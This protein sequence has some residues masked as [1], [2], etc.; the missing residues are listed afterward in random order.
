M[1]KLSS[2]VKDY[3]VTRD[4]TV[5]ALRDVSIDFRQN[6]FVSI[7]GPSG[8]GKTT[9][10][11]IVGG[12]DKYTKGDLVINGRSTKE[13]SDRDWD[14][15]RNHRIGFIFQTYNLIPHQTVLGNVELA[16]TIAGLSKSE[17]VE[18]AKKALAHVGLADQYYK[19]P[20]QLSG[21]QCQR[22]AIA[23]ALVNDPEIVLADEPTGA[24]DTVTSVQIMALLKEI[25]KDRLVIMVTHNA[26][27]AEE[28]ST[29]IIRLLDGQLQSDDNP[30]TAEE[31]EEKPEVPIPLHIPKTKKEK[32]KMSFWTAFRLSLQNLF[33]KKGRTVMTSIAGSIGIIGVSLVL[34]ISFGVQTYI[35]NMEKDLLSAYPV[36]VTRSTYDLSSMMEDTS[37]TSQKDVVDFIEGK[38][39]VDYMIDYLAKQAQSTEELLVT[40]DI[41]QDFYNFVRGMDVEFKNPTAVQYG[42][43]IDLLSSIYTD[44]TYTD[45]NGSTTTKNLSLS[46]I[47]E[48]Y[49]SLLY[50]T[51]FRN[52]ASLISTLGS[53]F[54]EAIPSNE[55]ITSQYDIIAGRMPEGKN[56]II[57]VVDDETTA[58]DLLLA[59]L[60]YYTQNEFLNII[61]KATDGN[62]D[63]GLIKDHFDFSELVSKKFTW[64]P[65]DTIMSFAAD[66]RTIM[67]GTD[68]ETSVTVGGT[69]T[70]N[71]DSAAFADTDAVELTVAGI[72]RPKE[73]VNFGSLST[74]LYYTEELTS[75]IREKSTFDNSQLI[76]DLSAFLEDGLWSN[77]SD[78][79]CSQ[80]I[81]NADM[82]AKTIEDAEQRAWFEQ[83]MAMLGVTE[84]K[85]DASY[86]YEY[87]SPEAKAMKTSTGYLGSSSMLGSLMSMFGGSGSNTGL[88]TNNKAFTLSRLGAVELPSSVYFYASDF[89]D[90]D[91][92]MEYLNRWNSDETLTLVD[93]D[94]NSYQLAA[95]DREKITYT[96]TLSIVFAMIGTLINVI[97]YALVGFTAL[98]L[99]VSSVMIGIIT[100]VSVYERT[101][102]IGI[103]RSLGG[104]K[105]D[106]SNLFN[107]ETFIIGLVSGLIGIAFTYFASAIIN[108][109]LIAEN[110]VIA[111]FPWYVAVIMVAI[112]VT[113]TLIAGIIPSR[114]AARKDP[115]VALRTE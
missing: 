64:Y 68:F 52:N 13:F 18:K 31:L 7:L 72:I 101:K 94:G 44:F 33:T 96:D 17:R 104:R 3:V 80:T 35:T 2:I 57:L 83:M 92:M 73:N 9:L 12:L 16:L 54:S 47:Q 97:T 50:E 66:V 78:Y 29:R 62:Y 65:L 88:T 100:Y 93:A 43:G 53:P 103:I 22:V 10:L 20:N 99:V 39:G 71:A 75:Y 59:R 1:L 114:S 69:V 26:D 107:A 42:Y 109:L 89:E 102:E 55:Y 86:N 27:L 81:I 48:I 106:V 4:L 112:S 49:T 32:A 38:V 63:E 108:W 25:A 76:R 85:F 15:Y 95:A 8:C 19:R 110:I 113:L 70:A 111:I 28:Y 84:F 46:A 82:I 61:A 56:E 58:T 40:N 67:P 14:V 77:F 98:S 51:E 21:G 6:E 11:N 23:R 34:A 37:Y 91:L 24:L 60:G 30:P 87:Y 74:G 115:V 5:H 45:N 105:R 41:N 90:K 36:S 79:L